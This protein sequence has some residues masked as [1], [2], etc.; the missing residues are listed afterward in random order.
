M[1]KCPFCAEEIQQEAIVCKH[2]GR[3]LPAS[4]AG[5]AAQPELPDGSQS[6]PKKKKSSLTAEILAFLIGL[7]VLTAI[8]AQARG[9][10]WFLVLFNGAGVVVFVVGKLIL[11]SPSPAGRF[12]DWTARHPRLAEIAIVA[13]ISGGLGIFMSNA[14]AARLERARI[15]AE[16]Q[17]E[18]ARVAKAKA[19]AK[20]NEDRK[21]IPGMLA[22]VKAATEA[23]EWEKATDLIAAAEKIDPNYPGLAEARA[24]IAPELAKVEAR[25]QEERRQE[26]VKAAL[27]AA[28]RVVKDRGLC[29]TPKEIADAWKKLRKVKK[30]DRGYRQAKKLAN[31]LER[32]R[33][34]CGRAFEKA[35]RD[36][37]IQQREAMPAKMEANFLDAG[38]DMRI[39]LHGR[40][41]DKIS[42]T[43]PLM[44][45]VAVHKLTD[46]TGLLENLRKAGFKR[47]TFKDGY[48]ERYWFDLDP[49]PET[50]HGKNVLAGLG[51]SEPIRLP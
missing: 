48:N 42:M 41:K 51:L 28:S 30:A 19:E 39:R 16:R 45:R 25:R 15:A 47:V 24:T 9:L 1:K 44:G 26:A 7:S 34:K 8:T 21:K 35:V 2:C 3:D 46:G 37:M 33:K 22:Q 29:D 13:L 49:E 17:A 10:A 12:A 6:S 50:G 40:Y 38:I 11:R 43:W 5:G 32:C 4:D 31:G 23:S 18:E 14:E 27:A 36:V 20:R